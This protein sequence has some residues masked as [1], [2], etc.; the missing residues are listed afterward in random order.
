MATVKQAE[1]NGIVDTGQNVIDN[2][3]QLATAAGCFF[4][5][6]LQAGKWTFIQNTTGS[7]VK[8]FSDSNIVGS[9]QVN[10]RG[11]SEYYNKCSIE[12]PHKDIRDAVDTITV[13]TPSS[14]LYYNEQTNE[15]KIQMP[16]INDPV[17]AQFLASR[18]LKQSRLEM[19]IR[20]SSDFTANGIQAGEL[21]DVTSTMHQFT[22][23]L[24][25]VIEISESD[26]D[27]GAILF[28]IVALEY[29]AD[30]YSTSGLTR[31]YRT[32]LN[33]I[34]GKCTNAE[35]EENNTEAVRNFLPKTKIIEE[36]DCYTPEMAV[37]KVNITGASIAEE[38]STVRLTATVPSD[39]D[40]TA[41]GTFKKP[42]T[43]TGVSANEINVPLEG[44]I[45]FTSGSG[46]IDI[47]IV[48]DSDAEGDQT[49]TFSICGA[50]HNVT[51]PENDQPESYTLT[52]DKT[53]LTE[54]E[55]VT[56]TLNAVSVDD[57]TDIAYT[58][59]GIQTS[60]LASD[61]D[62]LTGNFNANWTSENDT[63][64]LRFVRD[65]DTGTETINLSLDNGGATITV[66]LTDDYSYSISFS[67]SSIPEG[68]S[69]TA[70]ISVTGNIPD[71]DVPYTITG[72]GSSKVTTPSSLTGNVSLTGGVGSLSIVTADDDIDDGSSTQIQLKIGPKSGKHCYGT[73]TLTIVDDDVPD[74]NCVYTTVPVVWCGV[75]NGDDGHLNDMTV[76]RYAKFMTSP[77]LGDG[78]DIPT[79]VTVT[80]GNPATITIDSTTT[81][82]PGI[83]PSSG[84][85][86]SSSGSNGIAGIEYKVI[87][88]F[89]SISA[90][91]AI[92]G[93]LTS[94]MGVDL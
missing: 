48:D 94:V 71:G 88:S 40:T 93:T 55:E 80:E 57:G 5:W 19:M 79:A 33:G 21:I 35:I 2:L 23:K 47:P 56:F 84:D 91:S 76:M 77:A 86:Y 58:I 66:S 49:F 83:G 37:R 74:N 20:F 72:S 82:Y 52:S 4:T 27:E 92:T 10:M 61:S 12:F 59:T 89:D 34:R 60:D 6:D 1:I 8:S 68:A 18:E 26:T 70:N 17:Q 39:V 90:S 67:P 64:T 31:D 32:K 65:T 50:S 63:I 42:Y 15:M 3:N 53:T 9:I 11:L 16:L 30:V 25:R 54:C 36:T 62:P 45:T 28:D 24:F 44:E 41:I 81:V 22:N 14:D 78:V 46:Y 13:S 51:I 87:T 7:S 73:A 29:D 38:G 75:Y 69:T 43:I 85:Y